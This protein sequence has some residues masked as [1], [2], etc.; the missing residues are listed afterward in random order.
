[1]LAAVDLG[2][3]EVLLVGEV[4]LEAESLS[5]LAALEALLVEDDFVHRADLLHLVD[6]IPAS[7]ALLRRRRHEHISQRLGRIVRHCY[8]DVFQKEA[9]EFDCATYISALG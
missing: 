6:A 8:A 5:A 3:F 1:M 2:V 4:S 7:R 9:I